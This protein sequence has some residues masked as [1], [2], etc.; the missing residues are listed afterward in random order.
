LLSMESNMLA[1]PDVLF[2]TVNFTGSDNDKAP[3]K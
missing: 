1:P 3:E 2:T